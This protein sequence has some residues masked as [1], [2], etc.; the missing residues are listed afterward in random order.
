MK[1]TE[2][3]KLTAWAA[4]GA[5]AAGAAV[6]LPRLSGDAVGQQ[7]I[8]NW[9]L[10]LLFLQQLLKMVLAEI[11]SWKAEP[12]IERTLPD[13]PPV[14]AAHRETDPGQTGGGCIRLTEVQMPAAAAEAQTAS[15]DHKPQPAAATAASAAAS[16]PPP[17][18]GRKRLGYARI[19][20]RSQVSLNQTPRLLL[21]DQIGTYTLYQ[22]GSTLLLEPSDH[23]LDQR[24]KASELTNEQF[25]A[26]FSVLP[27]P[28]RGRSYH[29]YRAQMTPAVVRD[30][31]GGQYELERKGRLTGKIV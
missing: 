28:A 24:I 31:G 4:A 13:G 7:M 19:A 11:N 5:A 30:C 27:A 29:L 21:T 6:V 8:T 15:F 2:I 18:G 3:L 10:W 12:M 1:R 9:L 26:L 17:A 22:A 14:Q 25:E 23:W 16:V 20:D